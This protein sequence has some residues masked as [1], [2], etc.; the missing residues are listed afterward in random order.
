MKDEVLKF[1]VIAL[2]SD[3]LLKLVDIRIQARE[4]LD[5]THKISQQ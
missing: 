3:V 1:G 4:E 2:V 5:V